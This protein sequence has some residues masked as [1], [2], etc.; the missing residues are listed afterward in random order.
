MQRGVAVVGFQ[1]SGKMKISSWASLDR[2]PKWTISC[3]T[4]LMV[5]TCTVIAMRLPSCEVSSCAKLTECYLPDQCATDHGTSSIGRPVAKYGCFRG[6]NTPLHAASRAC[7]C[8][9]EEPVQRCPSLQDP[10]MGV[11]RPRTHRARRQR[12]ARPAMHV[13]VLVHRPRCHAPH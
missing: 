11:D 4:D 13:R 10:G 1:G 8:R 7:R 12:F 9:C 3:P 2:I 6:P 5:L